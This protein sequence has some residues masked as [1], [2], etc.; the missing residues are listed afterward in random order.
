MLEAEGVSWDTE[1]SPLPEGV[2]PALAAAL[3]DL[4]LVLMNLDEFLYVD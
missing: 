3:S 2:T 4:C 1:G